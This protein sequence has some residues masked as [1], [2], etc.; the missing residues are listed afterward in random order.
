MK[1][2]TKEEIDKLAM[3][4]DLLRDSIKEGFRPKVDNKGCFGV[5]Y[6]GY[7]DS[8]KESYQK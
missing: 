2:L 1:D 8:G 6:N 4:A 5:G 3:E 7:Y